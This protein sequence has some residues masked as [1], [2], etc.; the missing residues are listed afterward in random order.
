MRLMN[1]CVTFYG[2][3]TMMMVMMMTM[4]DL[5]HF[6]AQLFCTH[7]NNTSRVIRMESSLYGEGRCG[8]SS[9]ST[10]TDDIS[11]ELTLR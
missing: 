3:N 8:V 9:C 4:V 5:C 10:V 1:R 2:T 7:T 11:V 6:R